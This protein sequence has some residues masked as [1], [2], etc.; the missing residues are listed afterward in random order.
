MT[1]TDTEVG[2]TVATCQLLRAFTAGGL[3][4]V[5]MKPVASGCEL[6][7]GPHDE[8]YMWNADV[9]GHAS[10]SSVKAD[11]QL[12]NPYRFM[13]PVAPHL[14]AREAGIEISLT[15]I[16]DC[17]RQLQ[18][19]ANV[20]LVEGAGGWLAPLD[21]HA[22]M[23][24]LAIALGFPVILVV[25]MRLGCINHALLTAQAIRA[26]GLVLAGWVANRVDPQ[27]ARYEENLAT[28]QNTL[29]APLIGQIAHHPEA[30]K[31]SLP[32]EAV[33]FLV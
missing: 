20:V 6:I 4:S 28:L 21:D 24:D 31:G 5:G 7:V 10:A 16:E 2:K 11:P 12:V 15:H 9:A 32:A 1:G 27:M 25:G 23:A 13:P 18:Q 8:P 30:E 3:S 33:A 22:F 17:C 19:Q 29:N 14:A 26:S